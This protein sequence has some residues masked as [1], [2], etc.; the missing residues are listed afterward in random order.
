M[1]RGWQATRLAPAPEAR[2]VLLGLALLQERGRDV[3]PFYLGGDLA[4]HGEPPRP[5]VLIGCFAA[6]R[7]QLESFPAGGARFPWNPGAGGLLARL[8]RFVSPGMGAGA[9]TLPAPLPFGRGVTVGWI[10]HELPASR[11]VRHRAV[12]FIDRLSGEGW[13][14]APD[15]GTAAHG[16]SLIREAERLGR[17]QAGSAVASHAART[18]DQLPTAWIPTGAEAHA[19]RV[20]QVRAHIAAGDV[21][22][23]NLSHLIRIPLRDTGPVS[24]VRMF[25]HLLSRNPVPFPA[26]VTVGDTAVL[27][28]SPERYCARRGDQAESRPIKGTRPRGRLPAADDDLA[29]ELAASPKD[30]AENVMIVDLVRNDLGRVAEVGGVTVRGLC[31]V[32]S[33]TSVHHLVSTVRARLRA[34][35]G[36]ADILAAI[37]PAGSMTGAP[38]I[39]AVE[40]LS[41][42][43][44]RER[45]AYAGGI[46]WFADARCF[47]LAMV[48]RSIIVRAGA[49][50][51]PVGGGI[52]TDS[53]P[54]AEYQE[55]LDKAR[56]LVPVLGG[57]RAAGAGAA[58]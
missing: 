23:V 54:M 38:K 11:L 6:D 30:R 46:G 34:G 37:H 51:L 27:A 40:I 13:W 26:L 3:A 18:S 25:L 7:L 9:S 31:E 44:G 14:I 52:V 48:I 36:L 17:A 57:V 32:E 8:E 42:L 21:Y 49:A 10:G 41:R 50:Y 16:L 24:L 15:G 43:E 19:R 1:T 47:D 58:W 56:S 45:G 39:R 29:R 20:R 2:A 4:W 55:T 35:V 12:L 33:F 28:L 5:F 22:Q 53:D